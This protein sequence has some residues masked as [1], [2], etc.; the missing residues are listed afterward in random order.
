VIRSVRQLR[1]QD[2]VPCA[3]TMDAGANVHVICP[4][5]SEDAVAAAVGA[6]PSVHDVIR[7]RVGSGP[8]NESEHLF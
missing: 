3:F 7:D 1:E 2:G 6:L 4:P 8:R 5:S